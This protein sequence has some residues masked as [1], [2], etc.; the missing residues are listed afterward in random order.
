[1]AKAIIAGQN[2]YT[3][4]P[5]LAAQH[6]PEARDTQFQRPTPHLPFFGLLCAPLALLSYRAAATVWLALQG[7]GLIL[8]TLMMRTVIAPKAPIA[9]ACAVGLL[10][11]A[12]GPVIE[13]LWIGQFNL[14]LLPFFCAA[15]IDLRKGREACGGIW[16][17]LLLAL[18]LTGWPIVIYLGLCRRWRAVVAAGA[19]VVT[20]NLLS[21]VVI[22]FG[23]LRDYYSK[24]GPQ[25]ALIY[26]NHYA[27]FSAYGLG[28][29]I[30]EGVR[31][32]T[33]IGIE[34]PA[35][36]PS[37]SLAT[38]FGVLAPLAALL[39]GL[40]LAKKSKDFDSAFGGLVCVSALI[41]PIAWRQYLILAAIPLAIVIARLCKLRF[42]LWPT[43][44]Y[45]IVFCLIVMPTAAIRDA[46]GLLGVQQGEIASVSPLAGFILTALPACAALAMAWLPWR[47]EKESREVAIVVEEAQ[48]H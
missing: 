1:M 42:P 2:P 9:I 10:C 33:S 22:G 36:W 8:S 43:S 27:N 39:Y 18:K 12:T 13:E 45:G 44:G 6:L 48:S 4:L 31:S 21:G 19:V 23:A 38:V 28:R 17:G 34:A 16:L 41:S 47:L 14:L 24:V 7:A 30:F 20:A 25:V 5:A 40:W 26:R 46:A 32:G 15:W 3:P 35:L 29:R 37:P 11:V